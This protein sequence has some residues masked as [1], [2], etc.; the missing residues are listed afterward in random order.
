M[1]EEICFITVIG[2]VTPN[3]SNDSMGPIKISISRISGIPIFLM[4][5]NKSVMVSF[6]TALNGYYRLS[7]KWIYDLCEACAHP[8]LIFLTR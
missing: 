2:H 5:S 1:L 6:V 8:S 7:E 3:E 4:F